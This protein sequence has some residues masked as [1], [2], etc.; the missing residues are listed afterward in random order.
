MDPNRTQM[1]DPNRTMMGTAPTLQATQTIKPVQCPVCRTFNPVG[2]MFCVDCGLI[3]DRALP[4][5]AFGAPT[6][7]MPVLIDTAGREHILRPG[8]NVLGRQGDIIIDDTRISRR[9]A[10]VTV[11]GDAVTVM[12]LGST[13]GTKVSSGAVAEGSSVGVTQ[14]QVISLGGFELTLSLPGE[15]AKTAMP[16][17]GKTASISVAP[18]AVTAAAMLV[19]GGNSYPLKAGLNTFGRKAENDVVIPDAYVSGKHGTIEVEE[20]GV[21]ITDVGSTNGTMLNDAKL[22][23]NMRTRMEPSDVIRLGSLELR[24]ERS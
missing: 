14:G 4:E 20:S 2:V 13:N 5:D 11:Q 23:A 22:G 10:M 3:F 6:I 7:Q 17:G 19:G 16:I 12:D 15:S 24:V 21:F 18:S 8:E 9:H 1:M